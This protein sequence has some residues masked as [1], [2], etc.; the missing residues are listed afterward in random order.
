MIKAFQGLLLISSGEAGINPSEL[1][2]VVYYDN[3]Y[4]TLERIMSSFLKTHPTVLGVG[5]SI[6]QMA[7]TQIICTKFNKKQL[8]YKGKILHTY[9]HDLILLQL[10][11]SPLKFTILTIDGRGMDNC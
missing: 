3:A 2:A 4:L 5:L 1:E 10:F 8:K 9:H 11:P 7:Y 6:S